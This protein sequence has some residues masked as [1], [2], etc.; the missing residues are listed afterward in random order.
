VHYQI[1]SNFSSTTLFVTGLNP[2]SAFTSWHHGQADHGNLLGTVRTLDNASVINLNCTELVQENGNVCGWDRSDCNCDWGIIS[3][4]GWVVINDTLNFCLNDESDWW[5]GENQDEEDL[6]IFAY[7]HAYKQALDDFAS[8]SGKMAMVPKFALGV[9]WTRWINLCHEDVVEIVEKFA[10]NDVPLDVFVLDMNWHTKNGWTGYSFDRNLFPYPRETL[11]FLHNKSLAVSVNLHDAD[12]VAPYEDKYE[13]ACKWL[14]KV[15]GFQCHPT[16]STLRTIPFNITDEKGIMALEDVVLADLQDIGVDFFWIDWQ[17]GQ[18]SHGAMGG[19]QNPTIW[20]AH[21]RSTDSARRGSGR[22]SMV[23]SRWGG[24]GA[25]RYQVGFSGDVRELSWENLAFQPFFTFTA[26]NVGFSMWSHD[27]VGPGD[28]SQLY[29]RWMQFG[30]VSGVCRMHDR[31]MSAGECADEEAGKQGSCAIIFPWEAGEEA[32]ESIRHALWQRETLLPY[33]YTSLW[34]SFQA[35][36]GEALVR[37]MYYEYP[38]EELAYAGN[39]SGFLPQYLLGADVI[40]SPVVKPIDKEVSSTGGGIFALQDVWFPKGQVFVCL[41]TGSVYRGSDEVRRLLFDISQIPLFVKAGTVLPRLP[42]NTTSRGGLGRARHASDSGCMEFHIFMA[43][44]RK[45][46]GFLYEDDGTTTDYV[47][48]SIDSSMRTSVRWKLHAHKQEIF[49]SVSS[50]GTFQQAPAKREIRFRIQHAPP[51][52]FVDVEGLC[53]E[54]SWCPVPATVGYDELALSVIIVVPPVDPSQSLRVRV[55]LIGCDP[56]K[57]EA[58]GASLFGLQGVFS[59][60]RQAK[61]L[62]DRARIDSKS[63]WALVAV[64]ARLSHITLSV[65]R[66]KP[67]QDLVAQFWELVDEV[68]ALLETSVKD[69]ESLETISTRRRMQVLVLL[70]GAAADMIAH[71]TTSTA[72]SRTWSKRMRRSALER[73]K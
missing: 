17:Q 37:P 12:G 71:S 55:R 70:R 26:A 4:D 20:T 46:S 35:G 2:Q 72:G 49:I 40:A 53:G 34:R 33:L 52:H 30:S 65:R 73:M 63:L 32:F 9:W 6:Y 16:N 28:D 8:I 56:V 64:P 62:L 36:P 44:K 41:C 11:S 50:K 69:I 5:D 29:V 24:L 3:R 7:G 42:A 51:A 57:Q 60:A 21:L 58:C 39:R 59:K 31:G 27:L 19:K 38:E 45:G 43:N 1:D 54:D 68:G 66:N 25:H 10:R 22:R 23:L 48:N 67:V 14:Q 18:A 47:R 61:G 15:N 13:D